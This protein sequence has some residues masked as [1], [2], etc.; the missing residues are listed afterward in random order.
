MIYAASTSKQD[1]RFLGLQTEEEW[2]KNEKKKEYNGMQKR[3]RNFAT[4]NLIKFSQNFL[5]TQAKRE[6]GEICNK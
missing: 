2:W 1:L 6:T 3:N 5:V 4:F